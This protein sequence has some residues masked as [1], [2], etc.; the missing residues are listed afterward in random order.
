[1]RTDELDFDLPKELIAQQPPAQRSASRLLHY[2]RTSR[3]IDHH[4]FSDLPRLLR[5]GDLLVFN[6][7]RVIPAKFALV[8]ETGG[9]IEGL[10]LDEPKPGQWRA[11]LRNL[12]VARPGMILRFESDPNL[13]A[14]VLSGFGEGEYLLE[15]ASP[16]SAAAILEKIGRMPLPPYIRREKRGDPLDELDRQRYQTIYAAAGA[17]ARAVAAPTAGLHFTPELLQQLDDAG[18]K[19]TTITLHV[20]LGTFKPVTSD[21]LETHPMHRERYVIPEIA[22]GALNRARSEKRRIIAVGTTSARV[23][24]SQPADQP[25]IPKTAETDLFIYPPYAWKHVG[26]LITNFHLPRSTLIALVAGLTGLD[27]QR[28]IYAEA[29]SQKYRFFS[30]GDAMFVEA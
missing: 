9:R 22:A 14:T 24:E 19:R 23:L 13:I 11:M 2:Q 8:K 30:Y 10:Y 12:G 3:A 25:F 6:D 4:H 16:D 1:M 5:R 21:S 7:A 15:I 29:I 20:G 26:A 27:E 17:A 28:R 18:I